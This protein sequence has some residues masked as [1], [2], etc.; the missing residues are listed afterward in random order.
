[1][2]QIEVKLKGIEKL[3]KSQVNRALKEANAATGIHFRIKYLPARFTVEGGRRLRYTPR[4]GEFRLG[5]KF[6]GKLKVGKIAV[7]NHDKLPLVFSGEGRRQALANPNNVRATRDKIVIPLPRKFNLSNPK[8]KIKM[9]DEIRRVTDREARDLSKF[10]VRQLESNL[11]ILSGTQRRR[12]VESASIT[13][14]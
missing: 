10:L 9:S 12:Y 3:S 13:N 5:L 4:K 6:G 8:S 11:S 7:S 1:M 2:L 14:G